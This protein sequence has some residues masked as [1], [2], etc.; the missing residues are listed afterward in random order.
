MLIENTRL[1]LSSI[2]ANKKRSFLTMLGIIIGIGSVIAIMTVGSSLT[3]ATTASME[4]M[5]ANNISV[6]VYQESDEFNGTF[7]SFTADVLEGMVEKYKDQID[8]ISMQSSVGTGKIHK[9]S[10]ATEVNITGVSAGYFKANSYTIVAGSSLTKSA[11]ENAN[12]S[13]LISDKAAEEVFGSNEAALGQQMEIEIDNSYDIYTV[14]GVYEYKDESYMVSSG[15]IVTSAFIPLK[16]AQNITHST[17]DMTSFD[18]VA[19]SGVDATTLSENIKEY[20]TDHMNLPDGIAIDS[21]SMESVLQESKSILQKITLAIALI[22]GIALL[23]GGIGVMN[24]M[25]VSVTERTREIGTRKA[26][27]AENGHI[28]MQFI[29]EAVILCL[30]GGIIGVILGVAIGMGASKAMGYP[31]SVSMMSIVV[32]VGFSMA[33]GLFF[34]YYPAR[35]AAKMNPIDALRYE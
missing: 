24:I 13:I 5:G 23:V 25:T 16:T 12:K 34:G 28:M 7:P 6:Y 33:V 3:A 9:G 29:T 30:V 31:V 32:S 1:A 11:Y 19:K 2:K 21:Y 26:L 22:A 14:I 10:S 15:K 4:S 35:N 27:G 8:G 17:D 20:L 18:L